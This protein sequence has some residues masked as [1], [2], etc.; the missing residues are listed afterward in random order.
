MPR[1]ISDAMKSFPSGHAQLSTFAAIFM[2]VRCH[3]K[4]KIEPLNVEIL[5]DL[6]PEENWNWLF[7]FMEAFAANGFLL[8]C[9]DMLN[10]KNYRSPTSLVGCARWNAHWSFMGL[11]HGMLHCKKY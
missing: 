11:D 4:L 7:T 1:A 6:H 9:F 5:T 10:I 8:F 3:L 2:V